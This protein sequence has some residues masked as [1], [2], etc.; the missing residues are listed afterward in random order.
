MPPRELPSLQRIY[1]KTV[2]D[3]VDAL[4]AKDLRRLLREDEGFECTDAEWMGGLR[5]AAV[6]QWMDLQRARHDDDD[7]DHDSPPP[8]KRAKKAKKER[9]TSDDDEDEPAPKNKYDRAA[10]RNLGIFMSVPDV[11]GG[12]IGAGA[13][14][15]GEMDLCDDD[16]DES[17]SEGSASP[18]ASPEPPK[19]RRRKSSA[20]SSDEDVEVDS[21]SA[22]GSGSRSPA[23]STTKGKGKKRDS[24]T[25]STSQAK[26]MGGGKTAR[27]KAPKGG[28]KSAE[29]IADS[30]DS[31]HELPTRDGDDDG[32]REGTSR[33]D[34]DKGKARAKGA[35]EGKGKGKKK[36]RKV[37]E[38]K[39]GDAP[40]GTD[41]EEARIKKLKDLLAAAS[42]PRAFTAATG[43]ER[44]LSVERRTEVLEGHLQVLGLAVK[45][46]RL[47]SLSKAKEVGEKRLLAK[48]MQE[49]AG[50]PSKTGL[51][52]GKRVHVDSSDDDG[53]DSFAGPSKSKPVGE[54]ARMREV[55]EQ[56]KA[57][58]SFLGD[59]SSESD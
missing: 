38:P 40:R 8:V 14:D 22:S 6:A 13:G 9:A 25:S 33:K 50:N 18:S 29:F 47:P 54:K 23:P 28:F 27:A 35:G 49:L 51:R 32:G 5:A 16:S 58:A 36:E 42:G 24:T 39:E 45:S 34:K 48:E 37:P 3:G 30:D 21:P 1:D 31:S 43:A 7:H 46:G 41:D 17:S 59:Q 15:L 57:F 2:R 26:K 44:T 12:A 19:K 56:R 52:D 53:G 55:V 11:F 10:E 4:K 20:A